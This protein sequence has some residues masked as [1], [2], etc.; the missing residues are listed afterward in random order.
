VERGPGHKEGGRKTCPRQKAR[1]AH[2]LLGEKRFK[3]EKKNL[4]EGHEILP[5]QVQ[6]KNLS[7]HGDLQ[8]E[9]SANTAGMMGKKTTGQWTNREASQNGGTVG[10]PQVAVR[11]LKSRFLNRT[12]NPCK[13]PFNFWY[14]GQKWRYRRGG[15]YDKLNPDASSGPNLVII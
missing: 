4:R 15:I 13:L 1:R 8:Y 14:N 9:C 7:S 10:F 11:F 2:P 3:E 5:I 12:I 6:S